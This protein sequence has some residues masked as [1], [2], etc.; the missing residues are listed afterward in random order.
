M[1]DECRLSGVMRGVS[2]CTNCRE[3][4]TACHDKC[5]KDE[6]GEYG[7]LAW[8]ADAKKIN[9]NRR[10]YLDE[11]HERYEEEKRRQKWHKTIS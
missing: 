1:K 7:Y 6:R 8:K 10:A 11:K 9:D 2:P 3:R 4:H 5:P